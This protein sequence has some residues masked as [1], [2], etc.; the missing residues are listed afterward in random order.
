MTT[1]ICSENATP[2]TVILDGG[3]TID[4]AEELRQLLLGA[5][6]NA[7][8][9]LMID[10]AKINHIDLFGFQ[11]LCSTQLFARKINCQLT[12]RGSPNPGI[13]ETLLQSGFTNQAEFS[14]LQSCLW[15][16]Q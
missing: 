13:D 12:W 8:G 4:R 15:K 7:A 5:V 16:T 2:N 3:I 9:P 6:K 11:L 10:L 1:I 14:E